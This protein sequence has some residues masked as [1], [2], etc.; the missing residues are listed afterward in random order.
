MYFIVMIDGRCAIFSGTHHLKQVLWV[1]S[2]IFGVLA[3]LN[4][5][6]FS[7]KLPYHR[8]ELITLDILL[9]RRSI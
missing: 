1:I 3:V 5:V 9:I 7:R 8:S 6:K 2:L 4:R